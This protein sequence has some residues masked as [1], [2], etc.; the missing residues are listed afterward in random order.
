[1]SE[2]HRVGKCMCD[3]HSGADLVLLSRSPTC[4]DNKSAKPAP[5]LPASHVSAP[6]SQLR[7]TKALESSLNSVPSVTP[8]APICQD[9]LS[10][11]CSE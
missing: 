5:P 2:S 9:I 10:T 8:A 3:G 6:S 1:M 4:K 7:R 11:A